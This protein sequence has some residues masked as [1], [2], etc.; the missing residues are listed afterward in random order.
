MSEGGE[1]RNAELSLKRRDGTKIVVLENSRAVRDLEGRVLFYE[2]TLTDITAAH[3]LSR[4]LSYDASHDP[5]T[6]LVNRREFAVPRPRL[7]GPDA[8]GARW[9]GDGD[10]VHRPGSLQDHQRHLRPRRRR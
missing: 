8:G 4:Q 3:E 5:L 2:G 9:Q 6:G 1:V 10:P 7:P